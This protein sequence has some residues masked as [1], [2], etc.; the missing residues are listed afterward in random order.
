M[1]NRKTR[2]VPL[3][4]EEVDY[5]ESLVTSGAYASASE[6]VCAALQ[7]LRDRDFTVE[8][9]LREEV[10]PVYDAMRRDPGRALSGSE[11][12]AAIRARHAERTK[13]T[14]RGA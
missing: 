4:I 7:A 9:W 8:R 5:V 2:A 11:V 12:A 14:K 13:T 6:V 3:P 10:L 1:T